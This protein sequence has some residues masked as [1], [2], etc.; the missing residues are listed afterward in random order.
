MDSDLKCAC[1]ELKRTHDGAENKEFLQSILKEYTETRLV[2][3]QNFLKYVEDKRQNQL[4]K[5]LE[6]ADS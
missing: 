2:R 4:Q 1:A 3:Q 5:W 6:A